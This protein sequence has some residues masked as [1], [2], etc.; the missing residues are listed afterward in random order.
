MFMTAMLI[1]IIALFGIIV[2]A[3]CCDDRAGK[4][5]AFVLFCLGVIFSMIG[6]CGVTPTISYPEIINQSVTNNMLYVIFTH[7]LGEITQTGAI[8]SD[9]AKFVMA[10]PNQIKVEATVKNS[11]Y[12]KNE[13]ISN[14]YKLTVEGE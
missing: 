1:W 3:F 9:K 2:G 8:T 11:R 13:I 6:G 7:P 4:T 10:N 5:I 14:I 12:S